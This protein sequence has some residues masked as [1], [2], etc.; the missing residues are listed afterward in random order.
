MK[1]SAVINV[2]L[3]ICTSAFFTSGCPSYVNKYKCP[4]TNLV[5]TRSQLV[6]NSSRHRVKSLTAAAST[7]N[8]GSAS[9]AVGEKIKCHMSLDKHGINFNKLY[10]I[11]KW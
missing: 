8:Y 6:C 10:F 3:S 4:N 1:L 7:I 5:C 9:V 11:S 2:F